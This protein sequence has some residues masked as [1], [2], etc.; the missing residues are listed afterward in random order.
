MQTRTNKQ[1]T[2]S[3]DNSTNKKTHSTDKRVGKFDKNIAFMAILG[4]NNMLKE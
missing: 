4:Y 3:F 2:M 1:S